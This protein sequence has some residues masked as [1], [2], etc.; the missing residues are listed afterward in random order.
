MDIL[1]PNAM[2]GTYKVYNKYQ[3]NEGISELCEG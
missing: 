3:M 2:I 1:R